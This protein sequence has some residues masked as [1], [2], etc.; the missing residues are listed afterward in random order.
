MA[1]SSIADTIAMTGHQSVAVVI[2]YQR[3]GGLSSNPAS[4][5]L[6]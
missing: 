3:R 1:P 4:T 5:L 2:G 6:E